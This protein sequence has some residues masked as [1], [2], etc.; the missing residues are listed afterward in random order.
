MAARGERT[1]VCDDGTIDILMTNRALLE[2]ERLAG[3]SVM[4]M[5][6]GLI[7]GTSG[8]AQ[9]LALLRAGMEAARRDSG[10]RPIKV[11]ETEALAVLDKAGLTNVTTLIV[12]AIAAV[13]GYRAGHDRAGHEPEGDQD[14]N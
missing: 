7:T 9:I 1:I 2:A 3:Q 4:M 12:E 8:V 13:I 5:S 10:E 14:P 11:S 6:R